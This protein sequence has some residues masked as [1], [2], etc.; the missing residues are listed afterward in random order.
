MIPA[1]GAE[2]TT[3]L[4]QAMLHDTLGNARLSGVS[5][6]LAHTGAPD[7]TSRALVDHVIT[8]RGA[9]FGERFDH[10]LSEAFEANGAPIVIIGADTPHLGAE[11]L[12]QAFETLARSD[13]VV[14]P[15]TEGGFYLLGFRERPID[16]R[17]AF[18]HANE[19][20]ALA[21]LLLARG[22]VEL[23][24]PSF[25]LDV[26][27]DLVE[28]MLRAELDRAMGRR[29]WARSTLDVLEGARV[30]VGGT[31]SGERARGMVVLSDP[32]S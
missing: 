31:A 23:L 21:E 9:T 14:G 17:G 19:A 25:D 10:A 13:A 30:V 32:S 2:L 22:S 11:A 16:V 8:Q 29:R 6:V 12:R 18:D 24:G 5:I 27:G 3:R 4:Y 15:S 28:L 7:P 1:L 20:A 26:P